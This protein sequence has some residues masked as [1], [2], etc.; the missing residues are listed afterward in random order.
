MDRDKY[1]DMEEL[2]GEAWNAWDPWM[3]EAKT[4]LKYVLGDQWSDSDK[5][6]LDQQSRP[7][8]VINEL[9]RFHNLLTGY[10]RQNRLS[11]SYK[12]IEGSDAMAA[13]QF[14]ELIRRHLE[15]EGGYHQVSRQF[16]AMVKTGLDWINIYNDLNEDW[17]SGD[18]RF[19]RTAWTKIMP[20]PLFQEMDLSDAAYLF[21]REPV[22]EKQIELIMPGVDVSDIKPTEQ[23]AAQYRIILDPAELARLEQKRYY[24]T[25]FWKRE[26]KKQTYLLNI[27]TGETKEFEVPKGQSREKERLQLILR[28]FPELRVIRKA[29]KTVILEL[30]IGEDLIWEGQDPYGCDDYPYIPMFCYFEPE[31][32]QLKWKLQGIIR[33]LRDPQNEKNKRRSQLLHTINT[34]ATSGYLYEEGA[35]KDESQ[36]DYASGPAVKIKLNEGKL[37]AGAMQPVQPPRTPLEIAKFEEVFGADLQNISGLNAEMMAQMEK[38]IPGIAIQLRQR[39][40]LIMLQEIFD[41]RRM[42]KKE[43]GKRYIKMVQKNYTPQKIGRILNQQPAPGFYTKDFGRY[44]SVVDESMTSPTQKEYNFHKLMWYHQNVGPVHPMI[45]M[46]AADFPEKYKEPQ[47]QY[48]LAMTGMGQGGPQNPSGNAPPSPENMR[49]QSGAPM[50][51]GS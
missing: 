31:Y 38:D 11:I 50:V 20:D 6:Y 27:R 33:S 41:N 32:D 34:I 12:P 3:R 13:D 10:Q 28:K 37:T 42:T 7:H 1:K 18:I 8:L 35:M 46:E 48:M 36:L 45:L 47:I 15:S 23:A 4:D 9:R 16:A 19:R 5:A 2:L 44:D 49:S 43:I 29:K 25:E 51:M 17:E 14:S 24:L 26:W 22:S 30:Y 21:R 40:G 39:Q